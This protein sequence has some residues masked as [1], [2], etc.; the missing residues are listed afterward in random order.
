MEVLSNDEKYSTI[1]LHCSADESESD[2]STAEQLIYLLR[3]E[4]S[5]PK[6]K[7]I[8]KKTPS[9]EKRKNLVKEMVS[10]KINDHFQPCLHSFTSN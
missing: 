9:A 7:E 2:R 8:I 5:I 4:N 3:C 6:L 1:N 10:L